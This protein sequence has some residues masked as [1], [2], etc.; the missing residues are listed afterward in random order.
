M[1]LR[2]IAAFAFAPLHAMPQAAFKDAEIRFVLSHREFQWQQAV[3]HILN[4]ATSQQISQ[5]LATWRH[6]SRLCRYEQDLIVQ[7]GTRQFRMEEVVGNGADQQGYC[8]FVSRVILGDPFMAE[9]PMKTHKRPPQHHVVT[10]PMRG[11]DVRGQ[12]ESKAMRC[13]PLPGAT[14][15]KCM[16]P[17]TRSVY[18]GEY[19]TMFN[20]ASF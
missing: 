8:L 15:P 17:C 10:L 20:T 6:R 3:C 1:D 12:D 13:F 7:S 9:G 19:E 11:T 14:G 16:Q 2:C 4:L 18:A 5:S